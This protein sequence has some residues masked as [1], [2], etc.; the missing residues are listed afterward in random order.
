MAVDLLLGLQW[1]D[2]GKGK[3]V[4]VLT[5]DYD[6]IARFQGGPNAGHTL[7]FDGNKHV[8]HT[9]PS[10]IFHKTALNV[11]GN[12]VVIDPVIF[13]KELENLDVHNIDYT[14]KLLISRKAHLILPTHRLLDAASETSKGKAKIGS[15]LKGI[16]PTYMDKTGRN[17]MRVGDLELDNWKDKYRALTK[18]H[19]SMLSFFDVQVEYDLDELEAEFDLGIEKLRTLQFIDSEEYLNS[20]IKAGKTIL[21]EGAQGSLL[22]IDFGTYPFVTSSNTTA[23]GAC[24]GL[25]IA[26]NRIGDVFG[27]FKAYTTRVGSGP[28][29]TELFDEDGAEM[30]KVGHEF[31]A[32]T[33]RARR[34]GWLD[35]VALKYAVDVNGVTKLMMMK[36][37]VLSGF[38]TLKICTSYNYKGEEIT[39]LPYNIEPENVTVNYTEFKG[40]EDD[41]TKMT[42]ADQLPKNLLD[43]VAF[44]EKE[45]GVPVT[46]VSVGP[47]RMQTINR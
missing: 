34:C 33:G 18:K 13:K 31:G 12:G 45:T 46:I 21:A 8:L 5:R 36:G 29:P 40:W 14:S 1:G 22:D 37:D 11:V 28:F 30:A 25:G 19:L 38:D 43:Y 27:I 32:T 26:P 3:I 35:L 42:T 9:I 15:T 6:I 2:E 16:G 17:G 24:T 10:G 20:A 39:H 7:I 44:I 4:D 47:D 23:A 41:L